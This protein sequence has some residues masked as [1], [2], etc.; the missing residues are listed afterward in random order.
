[1][2]IEIEIEI[3][4]SYE[5]LTSRCHVVS[6]VFWDGGNFLN[7]AQLL[8]DRISLREQMVQKTL[9]WLNKRMF[10]HRFP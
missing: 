2:E 6:N 10:S 4:V 8:R 7:I 3:W 5:D 1:M 9:R